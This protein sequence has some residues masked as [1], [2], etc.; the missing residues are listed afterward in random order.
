MPRNTPLNE[1][2]KEQISAYKL[3]EKSVSLSRPQTVG[4]DNLKDPESYSTR[5]RP[6]RPPKITIAARR[7]ILR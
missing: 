6:D 1:N 2:E 7:R 4:R 5:K 3:E